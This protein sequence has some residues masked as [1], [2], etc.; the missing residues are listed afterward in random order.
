M[1]VY[2]E[3]QGQMEAGD[4]QQAEVATDVKESGNVGKRQSKK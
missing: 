3:K 1:P 4:D 2:W